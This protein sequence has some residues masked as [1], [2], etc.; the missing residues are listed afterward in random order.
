MQ[1]NRYELIELTITAGTSGQRFN[2]PDQPKLR[3]TKLMALESFNSTDLTTSPTGVTPVTVANFQQSY[4]VLYFAGGENGNRIPLPTLHRIQTNT[5]AT[6]N[7]YVNNVMQFMGQQ[8]VWEKSYIL[9]GSS[10]TAVSN[11]SFLI[12]VYYAC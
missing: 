1:T 5:T 8:I 3:Y 4:L 12:G 9:T 2:F 7:P 11:F 6:N 10:V